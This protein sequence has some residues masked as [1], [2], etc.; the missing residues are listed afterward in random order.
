MHCNQPFRWIYIKQE[1]GN[2]LNQRSEAKMKWRDI[3][4]KGQDLII[5][6]Q[7]DL[8]ENGMIMLEHFQRTWRCI[9]QLNEIALLRTTF[10]TLRVFD[11]LYDVEQILK[12]LGFKEGMESMKN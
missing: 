3:K 4:S 2:T 7:K 6:L 8:I 11:L 1:T 9:K 5:V 12:E 10:L